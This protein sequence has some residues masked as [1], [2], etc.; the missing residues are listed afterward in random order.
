MLI[1][2]TI[3]QLEVELTDKAGNIT[4][5]IRVRSVDYMA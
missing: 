1:I 4:V 5:E 3:V 2:E